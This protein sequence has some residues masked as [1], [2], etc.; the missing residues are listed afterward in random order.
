M[1]RE[2]IVEILYENANYRVEKIK[3]FGV[4][5]NKDFWY[6]Q[7]EGEL[8][9]L[10]QGSGELE[11]SNGEKVLLKKGYSFYIERHQT[12]RVSYTSYDC[13]WLC[14]FIKESYDRSTC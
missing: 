10:L 4:V 1:R 7:N 14:L 2:E 5:S 3:S 12:H 9:Y 6:D 13:Q 8:V 11:F